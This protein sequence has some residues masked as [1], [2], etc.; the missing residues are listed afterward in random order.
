MN[1][2]EELKEL[3]EILMLNLKVNSFILTALSQVKGFSF[4][5]NIVLSLLK[6]IQ[7]ILNKKEK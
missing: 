1:E 6:N 3:R 4:D 2:K 7:E 5:S